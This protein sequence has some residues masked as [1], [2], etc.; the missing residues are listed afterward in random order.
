MGTQRTM[1]SQAYFTYP[2]EH[3]NQIKFK[4]VG[5]K[6]LKRSQS[7]GEI[8]LLK[9]NQTMRQQRRRITLEKDLYGSNDSVFQHW[10]FHD[11]EESNKSLVK[12]I[13]WF[14]KIGLKT[15]QLKHKIFYK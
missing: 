6:F 12:L 9:R 11:Y 13:R 8:N 7:T 3:L 4:P 15:K 2:P 14:S 5:Q 1:N 10:M